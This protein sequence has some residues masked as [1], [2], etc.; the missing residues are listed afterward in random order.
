MD[1]I[2]IGIKGETPNKKWTVQKK[3][4]KVAHRNLIRHFNTHSTCQSEEHEYRLTDSKYGT[5]FTVY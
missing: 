5:I 4:N 3:D 2:K 1:N